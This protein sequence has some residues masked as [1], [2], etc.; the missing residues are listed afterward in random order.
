MAELDK[1]FNKIDFEFE[2]CIK[3]VK[4]YQYFF[5]ESLAK[6]QI[7]DNMANTVSEAYMSKTI[8]K[9]KVNPP[10]LDSFF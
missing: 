5:N 4:D 10:R 8:E 3:F 2:K 6:L 9:V 1:F 7:N